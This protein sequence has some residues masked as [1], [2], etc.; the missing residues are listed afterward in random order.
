[1]NKLKRVRASDKKP[2]FLNHLKEYHKIYISEK[3]L[4]ADGK[5]GQ[6]IVRHSSEKDGFNFALSF[7]SNTIGN[8]VNHVKISYLAEE[9]KWIL[10][11]DKSCIDR[12]SKV[13]D[14][15]DMYIQNGIKTEGHPVALQLSKPLKIAKR[16]NSLF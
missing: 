12:F 11:T 1:M 16:R 4:R 7:Y 9:H 14:L 13:T 15:C 2:R 3:Q 6:F 5:D 8:K 10:G